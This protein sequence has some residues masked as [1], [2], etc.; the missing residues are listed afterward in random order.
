MAPH[1]SPARRAPWPGEFWPDERW[2][3]GGA[4]GPWAAAWAR[5]P[6]R[7]DA[8]RI[9]DAERDAVAEALHEHFAQGRLTREEHE[10]RLEVTLRAKTGA[11]LREVTKDLPSP[12][13][14]PQPAPS[15]HR[16]GRRPAPLFPLLLAII[17][18]A[19]F[20]PAPL[21]FFVALQLMLFLWLGAAFFSHSRRQRRYRV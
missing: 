5:Q 19:T 15:R 20:A 3:L 16:P 9:G 10:E 13:G 4:A 6:A 11:D 2:P 17:L 7:Q 21:S 8:L 14:L 12:T 1:R 18:I